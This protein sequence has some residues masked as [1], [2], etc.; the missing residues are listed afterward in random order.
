MLK[1]LFGSRGR[2]ARALLFPNMNCVLQTAAGSGQGR[3]SREPL[4]RRGILLLLFLRGVAHPG[5]CK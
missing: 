1:E 4:Q 5:R 3:V 2:C